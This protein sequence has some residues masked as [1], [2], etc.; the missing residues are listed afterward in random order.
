MDLNKENLYLSEDSNNFKI[1]ARL[2]LNN[3][4]LIFTIT[5][6]IF[7]L[8]FVFA[9]TKKK[10][11]QGQFQIVLQSKSEKKISPLSMLADSSPNI[12]KIV[13]I[14]IACL[15]SSNKSCRSD[16]FL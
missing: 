15:Q 1:L 11:W 10:V 4:Y 8:S 14:C 2:L 13:K 3:K 5:L 6:F 7:A 9:N 12:S 16:S